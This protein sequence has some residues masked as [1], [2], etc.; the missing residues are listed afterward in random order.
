MTREGFEWSETQGIQA[1]A[2][3]SD[4]SNV[5]IEK[6]QH[7]DKDG[8]IYNHDTGNA[9]IADASP[10]NIEAKYT[11]PF[12]DFG[13]VG[14]RKTMKYLK[15]SV[16]PEGEL[17]P[18]LR[19]QYDFTDKDVAQ[20][21]D[22]VLIGIPV[23]PIFGAATFGNAIFEGT[24]DPMARQVLEGSGHTV[25]FQ[26]RTEDQSPPYSINGLYI[27]YVPAGRR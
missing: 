1:S 9:F 14:T 2:L 19:T 23:P 10:F 13:D 5:G 17:A 18:I 24:N 25:S 12:L 8:Y 15:L 21:E 4:F 27:N 11:T 3:V 22:I 26:I 16:S 6:L 20:P 7:G